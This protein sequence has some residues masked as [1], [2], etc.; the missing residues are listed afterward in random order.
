MLES[1]INPKKAE[2]RPW[3][4]FFIGL[5][6]TIV[7]IVLVDLIFLKNY[8]FAKY[9]SILIITFAV[10]LSIPFMFYLIKYEE[11]KCLKIEKEKTLM[12][13]HGKAIL[14]FT[15]LFLG[16]MVAFILA[17][18]VLSIPGLFPDYII[19]ENFDA[20]IRTYC[21]INMPGAVEDCV[22]NVGVGTV[23]Q[24]IVPGFSE[25]LS[26]IARILTN[27]FYVMIFALLFSFIFGFGAIFIL[28]WNASVIATAIGIFI[29]AS[30]AK[31]H[32]GFLRYLVHGIPE[33]LAYFIAALGGGIISIAVIKHHYKD[34]KFWRILQDSL[35]LII[36]AIVVLIVSAVIEVFIIPLLF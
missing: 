36:L 32:T 24:G 6:W 20:Q 7:A 26:R 16:I 33:I 9:N 10:M 18:I 23:S 22:K 21:S 29:N 15:F 19:S 3:E 14:A 8:T 17:F 13:E 28:T 4:M 5:I 30:L 2:R 25:G 12:K 27:N 35:D 1:L 31:L 34:D 11:K